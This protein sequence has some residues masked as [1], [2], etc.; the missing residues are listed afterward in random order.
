MAEFE[1]VLLL[2]LQFEQETWSS[3][4]SL[5]NQQWHTYCRLH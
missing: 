2:A 5:L 1:T 4:G 3:E